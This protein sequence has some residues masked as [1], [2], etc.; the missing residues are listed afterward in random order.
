M[1]DVTKVSDITVD[2]LIDYLHEYNDMS[3]RSRLTT[4]LSA[5]KSYIQSE[6]GLTPEKID[7]HADFVVAVYLLVQDWNDNRTMYVDKGTVSPTVQT[8]LF[9]YSEN[10]I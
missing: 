1:A 4:L 6:T 10:L 7:S 2:D 8:I 9:M 5:A 3:T